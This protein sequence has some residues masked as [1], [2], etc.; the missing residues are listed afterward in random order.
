MKILGLTGYKQSGKSTLADVAVT[1]FGFLRM[2]FADELKEMI[3]KMW[4]AFTN[5]HINGEQKEVVVEEYGKSFREVAQIV[6]TDMFRS[7]DAGVWV[8]C[9]RRRILAYQYQMGKAARTIVIHDVRFDNEAAL[10]RELGGEIWEVVRPEPEPKTIRE[11]WEKLFR[12]DTRDTHASEQGI[13]ASSVDMVI[14]NDL[15]LEEYQEMCRRKVKEF[16]DGE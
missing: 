15:G 1:D 12:T 14:L 4:P 11:K 9:L 3:A 7:Y 2:G 16:V 8:R 10:V 5:D 13:L 6:G